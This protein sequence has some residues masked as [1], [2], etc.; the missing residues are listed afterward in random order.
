M[1]LK[2]E[3]FHNR[4]ACEFKE[5]FLNVIRKFIE[6]KTITASLIREL[7]DHIEVHATEGEGKYKTQRIM[8]FYRFVR[9][10]EIPEMALNQGITKDTRQ[11]V[12]VSYIPK[13]ITA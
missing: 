8:I 4:A 1:P 12:S 6:M 9:Y 2:Q 3:I 10:I 11:G 13:A 5:M 7:I